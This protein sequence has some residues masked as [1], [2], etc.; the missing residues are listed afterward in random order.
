MSQDFYGLLGVPRSATKE[1]IRHAY[2]GLARK[3]HP[4]TNQGSETDEQLKEVNHAYEIL[5]DDESRA[6]YN[7]ALRENDP[8]EFTA[9]LY[10]LKSVA[11]ACTV[12]TVLGATLGYG[13][14]LIQPKPEPVVVM[15][16]SPAADPPDRAGI[17]KTL[18]NLNAIK[19]IPS[20]QASSIPPPTKK[21]IPTTASVVD[22]QQPLGFEQKDFSLA[23]KLSFVKSLSSAPVKKA[24][25]VASRTPP[26]E[27][28]AE[29]GSQDTLASK[30]EPIK[31]SAIKVGSSP[32]AVL[33]TIRISMEDGSSVPADTLLKLDPQVWRWNG[34]RYRKKL[35][36][37]ISALIESKDVALASQQS[38]LSLGEI[39]YLVQQV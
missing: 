24:S 4:D 32:E 31:S 23:T 9:K 17:E 39:R 34:G 6:D 7:L 2:L 36:K 26:T 30:P 19:A 13:S 1:Q 22:K 8:S 38:G 33:S 27:A 12:T 18:E 20:L 10:S 14:T 21:K 5:S 15:V 11:L 28:K 35:A 25:K 29:R 16:P 37:F 3:Y